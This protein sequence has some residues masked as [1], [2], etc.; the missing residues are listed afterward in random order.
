M[1]YSP[2]LN[3][4]VTNK[5][6]SVIIANDILPFTFHLNNREP[7]GLYTKLGVQFDKKMK[8]I[9]Q[10]CNNGQNARKDNLRNN[11]VC[12]RKLWKI[13]HSDRSE[14]LFSSSKHL[15]A[16]NSAVVSNTAIAFLFSSDVLVCPPW[17][18]LERA[19]T[20]RI[21]LYNSWH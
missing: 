5:T 15:H 2:R 3:N 19:S 10:M 12:C 8:K 16:P 17:T 14:T 18:Y 7:I 9:C 1:D 11:A 6:N 21:E 13:Q 20:S 4:A